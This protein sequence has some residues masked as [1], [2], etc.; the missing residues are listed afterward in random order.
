[1]QPHDTHVIASDVQ[2]EPPVGP[3]I[4][5][6]AMFE[7]DEKTGLELPHFSTQEVAKVFFGQKAEWLRWLAR[8]KPGK[9]PHGRFVLDGEPLV[10]KRNAHQARYYTL[11]DVEKMAHALTQC[12]AIDGL[13]LLDTIKV[14]RHVALLYG[15]G[16]EDA[17]D[18]AFRRK[19]IDSIS[20]TLSKEMRKEITSTV[21]ETVKSMTAK[22]IAGTGLKP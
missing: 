7:R 14:I 15:I 19:I 11:A 2:D 13:Q 18:L 17:K 6:D 1:M 4:L 12:E 10:F 22:S 21:N 3:F 16:T 8:R 20:R 9:Y 5:D